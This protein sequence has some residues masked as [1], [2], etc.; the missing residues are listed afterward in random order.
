ME[1]MK[2]ENRLMIPVIVITNK[3]EGIKDS[4]PVIRP[5]NISQKSKDPLLRLP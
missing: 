4:T 2:E 3:E 1:A 5:T